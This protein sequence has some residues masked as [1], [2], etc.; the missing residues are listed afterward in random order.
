MLR[1]NF[2]YNGNDET[3]KAFVETV[4]AIARLINGM[5]FDFGE[6]NGGTNIAD[7]RQDPDGLLIDFTRLYIPPEYVPPE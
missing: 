2:G 7:I 6:T 1:D 5:Q 3:A 4:N